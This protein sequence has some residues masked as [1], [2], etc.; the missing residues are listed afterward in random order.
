MTSELDLDKTLPLDVQGVLSATLP[1]DVQGGTKGGLEPQT[2]TTQSLKSFQNPVHPSSQPHVGA[3]LVVA[4]PLDAQVGNK[5]KTLPLDVQGGIK[6]GLDTPFHFEPVI[7]TRLD[8]GLR[9]N[10]GS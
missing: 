10:D 8:S 4:L 1:L 2:T 9:R 7:E 6:G 5:R 3:T